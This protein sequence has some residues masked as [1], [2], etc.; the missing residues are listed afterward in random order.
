MPAVSVTPEPRQV[1]TVS[2]LNAEVR[3][4]LEGFPAIWVEGEVSNLA[5]PASGHL[6]LTLKDAGAQVRCAMWRPRAQR[7][8]FAIEDGM[9]LLCRARVGLYEPRGEFQ[10]IL[11]H[12]EPAGD[13]ALRRRFE[14]LK[15]KLAAEG[16]FDPARKLPLPAAIRTVGVV[17]SAS[18]AALHDVLTTLARRAPSLRVVVY[19]TA[20]Q[21]AAAVGEIV[22]AIRA[23]GARAECDVLLIVRG[24]GS[25]EDLWC[26]NDEAVARAIAASP[27][28][29]VSGVGHEVDT[30]IADF[31]ADLRAPTP[32]GAAER[33]SP[34]LGEQ[35][36]Q[37]DALALRLRA[38]AER[39]LRRAAERT[40][41]LAHRLA[42]L[43][44]GQRLA[45]RAQRLDELDARLRRA[46]DGALERQRARAAA[47]S[48]ALRRHA[49]STRLAELRGRAALLGQRLDHAAQALLG[50]RR[51]RLALA[52]GSL[53]ATSP[54]ATLARGYAIV[55]GPDGR[56]L[57]DARGVAVGAEVE[58]RLAR[59]R[60]AARVTRVIEP[61]PEDG[62]R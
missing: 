59:G 32:T 61:G 52:A 7:L 62:D 41:F 21:G 18:G 57:R 27:I 35:L 28:P 39:E 17:T 19:P 38:G 43:H 22:A 40:R 51:E 4:V 58:A 25:L 50:G 47:A 16:L 36:R 34:D 37:V 20:V 55:S 15:R 26:F 49:P 8:G 3:G 13:G 2:R 33:V 42:Q 30:T 44:P 23:A 60:L 9:Q 12:A 24:G 11:E 1:Y 48:A 10:L 29:T 14:E 6:Y 56:A 53:Q 45:Q 5:R 54:L 31:V 46:V